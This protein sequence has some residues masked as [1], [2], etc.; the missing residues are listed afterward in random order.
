MDQQHF[1]GD[2]VITGYGTVDGRLVCAYA[3]DFT[4][5]EVPFRNSCREDLQDHGNGD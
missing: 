4:V 2:G 1:Y 3:Q 5:S